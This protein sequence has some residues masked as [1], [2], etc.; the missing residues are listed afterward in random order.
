M[1]SGF[2]VAFFRPGKL[3]RL[4]ECEGVRGKCLEFQGSSGKMVGEMEMALKIGQGQRILAR[5][6]VW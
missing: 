5:S 4:A 3:R 1:H 6:V 2:H